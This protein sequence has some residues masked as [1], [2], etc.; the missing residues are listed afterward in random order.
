MKKAKTE[1]AESQEQQEEVKAVIPTEESRLEK[2]KELYAAVK[3]YFK[4][5]T[6]LIKHAVDSLKAFAATKKESKKDLLGDEDD[7]IYVTITLSKVPSKF[8]PRPAQIPLTHPIYGPEYLTHVCAL[9]KDPARKFKDMVQDLEVPCLAKVIGYNKLLR[10]YKQYES[11]RQLVHEFDLFFCDRNIYRMLPKATGSFFY[12][13]K[14]FPYPLDFKNDGQSVSDEIQKA[15]KSTYLMLGNGPHYSFK[16]ARTSMATKPAVQ[17]IVVGILKSL[18]HIL[19]GEVKLSKVQS[20]TIK[21]GGSLEL[22]IYC[23][24]GKADATSFIESEKKVETTEVKSETPETAKPAKTAKKAKPAK[25]VKTA[26][27]AKTAKTAPTK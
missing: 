25:T 7:F 1:E 22:P 2:Y 15:L 18:P 4:F 23:H 6:V 26:K 17:N 24:L 14:K 8:S 20:I 16:V 11:R 13:K 3:Q 5:D 12:R 19:R 10:N 9:V 21:M 27:A